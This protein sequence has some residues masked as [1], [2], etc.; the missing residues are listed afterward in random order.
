MLTR[1]EE[2]S[3]REYFPV[4]CA[5]VSGLPHARQSSDDVCTSH[6]NSATVAQLMQEIKHDFVVEKLGSFSEKH[7]VKLE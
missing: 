4:L 2:S 6:A 1:R 3:G 7:D 5:C